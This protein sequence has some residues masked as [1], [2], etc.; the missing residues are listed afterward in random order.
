MIGSIETW[1]REVLELIKMPRAI[2]IGTRSPD[3]FKH[4]PILSGQL[5]L[6]TRSIRL[7]DSWDASYQLMPL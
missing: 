1:R 4:Y 6:G 5:K 7:I 3:Q 2:E